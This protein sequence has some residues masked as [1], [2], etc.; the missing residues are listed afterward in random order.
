MQKRKLG[1]TGLEVSALGLG[2]MGMNHSYAPFPEK[3]DMISMIRKAVEKG[4]TFFDTIV[5]NFCPI[6]T[7]CTNR[8]WSFPKSIELILN[9]INQKTNYEY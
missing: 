7:I 6:N 9:G 8:G 3:K 5:C 1:S 2:C 4:V